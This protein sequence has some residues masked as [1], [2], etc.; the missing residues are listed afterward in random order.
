[1]KYDI[2]FFKMIVDNQNVFISDLFFSI[3]LQIG[4]Q[5]NSAFPSFKDTNAFYNFI[6]ENG[7]FVRL[8]IGKGG[9]VFACLTLSE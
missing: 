5:T 6:R 2:Q 8:A 4:R 3:T 1:M 9:T 7:G